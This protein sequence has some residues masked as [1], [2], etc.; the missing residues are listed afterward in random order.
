VE[1][2]LACRPI[3]PNLATKPAQWR[4]VPNLEKK[5]I[6]M[7][8]K[9]HPDIEGRE[10]GVQPST[11]SSLAKRVEVEL[12][13]LRRYARALTGNQD[14]GDRYVVA[15]L[16]ALLEDRSLLRVDP[17]P[18]IAL[19]RTFHNVWQTSGAPIPEEPSEALEKRAH[20]HLGALTPNSRE[21]LLLSTIEEFS[22]AEIGQIMQIPEAEAAEMTA[23]AHREMQ[24]SV[25]GK[26][27]IIEDEPLIALDLR[28]INDEMG[29]Q[30]TGVARTKDQAIALGR[31]ERPD[32]ILS[33]IQLA[34]GSSG[35]DAVGDLLREIGE[36]PVIFITAF[37]ERLLTG[38]KPEPALLITKP[39]RDAQV[40]TAVSQGMFFSS[41]VRLL[42]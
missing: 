12:P 28:T 29:H 11:R 34:D 20:A 4:L 40:R 2:T 21:A 17:S 27:M 35:L 31:S 22:D 23:I 15:T 39:F 36:M 7:P 37:P 13:Y 3:R 38:E 33:D 16:E 41:V 1:F 18:R 32:L 10:S 6:L 25:R 5:H 24:S 26:V 14:S 42:A 9:P 30:V 19:F 8:S